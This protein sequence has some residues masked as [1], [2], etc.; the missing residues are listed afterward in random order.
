M[1]INSN[2]YNYYC[3]VS[4][5]FTVISIFVKKIFSSQNISSTD[6]N[7]Y[8]YLEEIKIIRDNLPL[9]CC[10]KIVYVNQLCCGYRYIFVKKNFYDEYDKSYDECEEND[11]YGIYVDIDI[12]N[13]IKE[14]VFVFS[15]IFEEVLNDKN[16]LRLSEYREIKRNNKKPI[17]YYN[18]EF[19][20][21]IN[22]IENIYL[23]NSSFY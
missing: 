3:I 21:S 20:I 1:N 2:N 11:D 10:G 13:N 18:N 6:K 9:P 8:A 15:A 14:D 17:K 7:E 5:F 22:L 16:L 19:Y 4:L 12:D 23:K